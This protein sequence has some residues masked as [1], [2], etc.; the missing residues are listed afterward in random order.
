MQVFVGGGGGVDLPEY[1][2]SEE[3][4]DFCG[5]YRSGVCTARIHIEY[6]AQFDFYQNDN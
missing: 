6:E 3:N 5:L 1:C 2:V 4:T